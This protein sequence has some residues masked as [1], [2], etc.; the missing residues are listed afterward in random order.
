MRQLHSVGKVKFV[1]VLGKGTC[2]ELILLQGEGA[3]SK[4]LAVTKGSSNLLHPL[5]NTTIGHMVAFL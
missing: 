2:S 4:P 1:F 5:T 3:Q